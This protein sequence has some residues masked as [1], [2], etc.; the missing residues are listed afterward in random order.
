ME[1][2]NLD[3][4]FWAW[5]AL[6]VGFFIGCLGTVLPVLPGAAIIFVGV[7]IHKL[8]LP[9][10]FSWITVSIIGVLAVLSWLIDFLASIWG[11]KLGGATS[12]GLIGA[13]VGGLVGLPFG[14]PGLILGPFFG[15]IVGDIVAKRHQIYDLLKSGTGAAFGFF[16]SLML[17]FIILLVIAIMITAA[18]II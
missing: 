6:I 1:Y 2:I 3:H 5:F 17:R 4:H 15:A 7:L 10:T 9:P 18:V 14:L 11:A 13:A 16:I 8:L 12:K